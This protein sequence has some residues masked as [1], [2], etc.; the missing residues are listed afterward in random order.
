MRK[1]FITAS[2]LLAL[3]SSLASAQGGAPTLDEVEVDGRE[4]RLTFDQ[5]MLTWDTPVDTPAIRIE[6]AL[7]CAWYWEDDTTLTCE[8]PA[9]ATA[10]KLATRYHVV[11]GEGLWTQQGEAFPTTTRDAE[12]E[13]A[14]VVIQSVKWNAGVPAIVVHVS[15]DTVPGS[16][17]SVLDVRLDDR[18]VPF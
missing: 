8:G 14:Q 3:A 15:P 11:I 5:P 16:L 9:L 13:R 2:L 6:P 12:T 17:A 1:A 4:V 7:P 18:A 10:V